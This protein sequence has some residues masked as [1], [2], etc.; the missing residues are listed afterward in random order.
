MK[1]LTLKKSAV[2]SGP[3]LHKGRINKAVISPAENDAGILI[4]N[5]GCIY[6]LTP[7]LVKDTKRGTTI[8]HKKS[9]LH[10][11]EH[12]VSAIRGMGIDN[13]L[14][15]IEGDEPPAADGSSWPYVAALKKA[16]L[17][18]LS[19]EKKFID[20]KEPMLVEDKGRYLAVLPNKGLKVSY[21][22]DFSGHG[23]PPNDV[24]EQ[25]SPAIYE[26][27]VSKART[28]GF[29]SEIG[30]LIAAGLIK[31]ANLENAILLDKG[32]PVKGAL[33]YPDELTRHKILDIVGDFGMLG[34]N[35]N[36]HIIAV[37][38]GHKHNVE[39]ARKIMAQIP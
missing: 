38:T 11:V 22:A 31:G 36:M 24:S 26:N 8:K 5:S 14:I 17:K 37:K 23:I 30:W 7:A 39:M 19:K 4:K 13:C 1:Q 16:G 28:F 21:F 20:I 35:L 18:S 3:G 2:I 15:D 32:K 25:I 10:T 34:A 27:R 29:K 33:R 12:M 6:V 9:V